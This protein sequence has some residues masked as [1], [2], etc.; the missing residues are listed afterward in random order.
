VRTQ[1]RTSAIAGV[2]ASLVLS[3]PAS[4]AERP[5]PT[6]TT[7]ERSPFSHAQA[8]ALLDEVRSALSPNR[9]AGRA[10]PART[11]LTLQL[12]DL[13]RALP[14]LTPAERTSA[15]AALAAVPPPSAT[16]SSSL[17]V[18]AVVHTAHFC[19]H[20]DA[21]RVSPAWATTT[22]TTLEQVWAVEVDRLG[23]RRPVP[24]GDGLVD[25]YLQDLGTGFY[26]SCA[27]AQAASQSTASCVFDDDFAPAQFSGAAPYDSLRATAAHEFFHVLQ[28]AYDTHDDVWFMEG[29]AVWAEDR[30]FGAVNDYVQ[31]LEHSAIARPR[32][33]AD[34]S[35]GSG[36]DLFRRYGAVLFWT[37]LSEYFRDPGIVRRVWEYA[38][39]PAYSLQAV[40]AALAERGWSFAQAFARFGVWNTAPARWYDDGPLFPDPSWWRRAQLGRGA[41]GTGHRTVALDHLTNAA[42]LIRPKHRLPRRTRL[43]IVIDGPAAARMPHATVQVRRRNGSVRVHDVLLSTRGTGAIRVAFNPRVVS[44]VVVTLTNASTRMASCG[45][46]QTARYSCA[47]TGADDGQVFGVRAR[48]RLR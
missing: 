48:V 33:P 34:D 31:Y 39:G 27:P 7:S 12:A 19:V 1:L 41:R 20:Y 35:G 17:V 14:A 8:R 47:G 16:C 44:A 29:T 6:P 45:A 18:A 21:S 40:T 2:A 11:E 4:A 32:V 9:S 5:D 30:V 10:A 25:V 26:G 22:A 38:V 13:R 37:F 15:V 46:D 23:F 42:M 3:L 28:F 36:G 43:R 24:D